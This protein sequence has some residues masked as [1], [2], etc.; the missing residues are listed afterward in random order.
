[1][2]HYYDY[3][4]TTGTVPS[5]PEEGRAV[6]PTPVLSILLE[7]RSAIIT[8]SSLYTSHLH[9]IQ[10]LEEDVVVLGEDGKGPHLAN[11]GVPIANWT[12][13]TGEEGRRV[14]QEGG[15][16]KRGV[17]YSLT[18]RDV[19]KVGNAKSVGRLMGRH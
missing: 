8:R 19:T 7:P 11:V 10:E 18:C 14:A 1:M 4:N 12:M 6:N 16:L 3:L 15:V 13:L 5:I 2:F 17:R 9:G